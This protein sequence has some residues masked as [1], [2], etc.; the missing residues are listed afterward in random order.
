[1]KT[2]L[3]ITD[4][5]G[6]LLYGPQKLGFKILGNYE[7]RKYYNT[8]TF[9]K[10]FKGAPYITDY[11]DR[12]AAWKGLDLITSH[13]E[14]G[15]Y[16]NL[17]TGPNAAERNLDPGDIKLFMDITKYYQPK[18]FLC[19]NLPKSLLA[20]T[21]GDWKKFFRDYKIQFIWVS[22]W[23]YGNTQKNRNRLFIS[24]THR[25]IDWEFVPQEAP[26]EK[27][28]IHVLE[29]VSNGDP[30]HRIM[31]I[32]EPTRWHWYQ[33]NPAKG[34]TTRKFMTL[35][36]IQP[37]FEKLRPGCNIPYTNQYGEKKSKPGYSVLRPDHT[38]PV[39]SGG[40]SLYDNF[41]Y[42]D[43]IA[44]YIRPLTMR[45]RLAIQGF[46]KDFVLVPGDIEYGSQDH[47]WACKQTGKCMP[48]EFPTEF[49]RQILKGNRK[50]VPASVTT[51]PPIVLEAQAGKN[52][53]SAL[54]NK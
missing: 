16:S 47:Q 12:N 6:S 50:L 9:E 22:N 39:L 21:P 1:M 49:A 31:G 8:G 41:W 46:D 23:G 17:Y 15:N 40:G 20:V 19:D 43:P 10:N 45:E 5:I 37:Y 24:G 26:H 54:K 27:K 53:P 29:T 30:N 33:F 2:A 48:V 14:C 13:P 3:G 51:P 52:T 34:K 7:W 28:L 18:H 25:D 35:R 38:A 32:D 4:G 11:Q 44:G 42:P 36:E